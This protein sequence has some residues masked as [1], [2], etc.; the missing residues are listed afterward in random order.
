MVVVKLLWVYIQDCPL[1]YTHTHIHTHNPL[2][3]DLVSI[4]KS[5]T[6]EMEQ[7]V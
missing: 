6:I 1:I 7:V 3:K 2:N 5:L 4:I